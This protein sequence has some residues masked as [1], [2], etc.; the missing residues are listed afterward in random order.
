[1]TTPYTPQQNGLS[2]R[3]NRDIF[4][5]VLAVNRGETW[6]L[7]WGASTHMTGYR[8]REAGNPWVSTHRNGGNLLVLAAYVDEILVIYRYQ[9]NVHR[10]AVP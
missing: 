9:Q 8:S 3:M 7:D 5:H 1:M 4:D 6:I 10:A 2:E